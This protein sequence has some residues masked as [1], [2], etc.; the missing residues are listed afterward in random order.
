MKQPILNKAYK[1]I[2][3]LLPWTLAINAQTY[4]IVDTGQITFYNNNSVIST[5]DSVEAFYG[6]DAQYS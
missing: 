4:K 3:I 5:P 1:L 6:Q 2:L